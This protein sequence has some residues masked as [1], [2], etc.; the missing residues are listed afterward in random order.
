MNNKDETS[1]HDF[2]DRFANTANYIN[3]IFTSSSINYDNYDMGTFVSNMK[4]EIIKITNTFVAQKKKIETLQE[5]EDVAR[6]VEEYGR[7]YIFEHYDKYDIQ[8]KGPSIYQE[9]SDK[10][11]DYLSE[12]LLE[13]YDFGEDSCIISKTLTDTIFDSMINFSIIW[14]TI[15]DIVQAPVTMEDKLKD[16]GMSERDFLI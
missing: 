1:L 2:I 5:A 4:D 9:V 12:M 16:V 13:E 15:D 6:R 3:T 7:E 8:E 11:Y 10:L 14:E